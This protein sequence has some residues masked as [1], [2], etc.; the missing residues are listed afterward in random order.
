[1]GASTQKSIKNITQG[2]YSFVHPKSQ[3][4]LQISCWKF[5]EEELEH[6]L[7]CE[8][9][10]L[11]WPFKLYSDEGYLFACIENSNF[12][13]QHKAEKGQGD[14]WR[15]FAGLKVTVGLIEFLYSFAHR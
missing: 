12:P 10:A 5:T 11:R 9:E 15:Q 1:M 14:P 7:D 13:M 2:K 4:P 6:R 3:Y 8:G